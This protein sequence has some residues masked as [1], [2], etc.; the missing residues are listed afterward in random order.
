MFFTGGT[1]SV[2]NTNNFDKAKEHFQKHRWCV[3]DNILKQKYIKE[4]YKC[5]PTLNYGWWAC[6]DAVH[7]KYSPEKMATLNEVGLRNEYRDNARK[8]WKE[9]TLVTVKY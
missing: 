5:V 3:I 7:H 9:N 8:I 6:V 4:I 2:F 1:V